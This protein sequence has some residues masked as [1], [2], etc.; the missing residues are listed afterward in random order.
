MTCI[1]GYI[2]R[3][4]KKNIMGGDSAVNNGNVRILKESKIFIREPFI[5]GCTG[6]IR[7]FQVLQHCDIKMRKQKTDET[8][9]KYL[10][11]VFVPEIRRLYKENGW[12]I[13]S[14]NNEIG[15]GEFLLG[16]KNTL[17]RIGRDLSVV[18]IDTD[19]NACGSGEDFAFGSLFTTKNMSI[20]INEKI[21]LALEAASEYDGCVRPPFDIKEYSYE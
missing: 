21:K 1:V 13:N 5:I 14:S 20:N 12:N 9:L 17:Y 16:Y 4:N 7:I 15:S 11:T 6:N 2:D 3:K 10:I 8:D 19:Y 18:V